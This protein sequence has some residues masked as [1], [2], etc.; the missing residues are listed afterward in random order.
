M[1]TV[2]RLFTRNERTLAIGVF[3]SGSTIGATVAPPLIVYLM[4]H[5]GLRTAFLLPAFLGFLWMPLWWIAYGRE[6]KTDI[7]AESRVSTRELLRKSSSWAIMSC[8]F[9]IGPVMQFF[10]YWIPNYLFGV[11]HLT[12]T[13]IGLVSWITFVFGDTGGI[14]GGWVAGYLHS[15]G[16]SMLNVRRITMYASSAVCMSSLLVPHMKSAAATLLVIGVAILANSF[17]AVNMFG[18]VSDLFPDH[19][20]G[21]ATGL[22]GVAGG[23][24]GLLFPLLTGSLVDHFSYTPVFLLVGFMPL[25]GTMAL[26][27]LGGSYQS[28]SSGLLCAATE[29]KAPDRRSSQV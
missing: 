19:Q 28:K 20:V 8:R 23:L 16:F 5:Y 2:T 1:K 4:Q 21:R 27:L 13:Q 6:L 12:M 11:R 29:K 26:F 10:W 14:A 3:N 17:V 9:F 15:R 22:T 25:L 7:Q 24:S 18:A